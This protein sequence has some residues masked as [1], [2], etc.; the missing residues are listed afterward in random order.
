MK[1]TTATP[2][3]T[4]TDLDRALTSSG[5]SILPSSGFADS[6]MTSVYNE[7]GAPAPIPFPWKRALPGFIAALVAL[8]LLVATLPAVLYSVFASARR[9]P[10]VSI[11]WQSFAAFLA[12]PRTPGLWLGIA[13]ALSLA[14]LLLCRRLVSSH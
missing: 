11:D 8:A 7:A 2:P 5:D 13:L 14:C 10:A 6:V 9:A 3:L 12:H 4:D 1:P